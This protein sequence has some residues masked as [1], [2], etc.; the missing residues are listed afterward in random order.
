MLTEQEK[1]L[2][3]T[4]L[5]KSHCPRD[6]WVKEDRPVKLPKQIITVRRSERLCRT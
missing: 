3:E 4:L 2:W 6:W 5:K 1:K